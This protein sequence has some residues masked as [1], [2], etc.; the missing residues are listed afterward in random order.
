M[1]NENKILNLIENFEPYG[2]AETIAILMEYA[3]LKNSI[4]NYRTDKT[5]YVLVGP[6]GS[7]KSTF[8]ANMYKQNIFGNSEHNFVPFVNR[9]YARQNMTLEEEIAFKTNLL[10]QG[11]SFMIESAQFDDKYSDFVKVIKKIYDYDVCL[12]YL[13]KNNPQENISMV[14][15]RKTE[16]GHGTEQVELNEDVITKMYVTDSKNLVE[17]LPYCDSCFIINNQTKTMGDQKTKP[18]V[19]LQKKLN[20][21][22]VY[23]KEFKYADFLYRKILKSQV[24]ITPK[25]TYR[26][27]KPVNP[28]T[29]RLVGSESHKRIMFFQPVLEKQIETFLKN[30][31]LVPTKKDEFTMEEIESILKGEGRPKN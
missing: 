9:H 3:K 4:Q 28:R 8:I 24:S 2:T 22:I 30:L 17:I 13:T 10:D 25:Q 14:K 6:S 27:V 16:G 19:L 26:V 15:K 21:E 31:S 23:N 5:I 1:I 11:K 7:G 12:I 18:I 29:L 20:G